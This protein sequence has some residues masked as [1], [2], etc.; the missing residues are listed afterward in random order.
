MHLFILNAQQY[1]YLFWS[2]PQYN[3]CMQYIAI[4]GRV[5]V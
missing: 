4:I 1:K 2:L 3:N 5:N